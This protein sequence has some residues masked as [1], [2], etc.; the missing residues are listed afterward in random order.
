MG[1]CASVTD[2]DIHNKKIQ[3]LLKA[4]KKSFMDV[5]KLLLLGA[6][7]SG[8]S[9]V[10]KQMI[11]IY[12]QGFSE[13]E[14]KSYRSIIFGNVVQSMQ[15][16]ISQA[17][18]R[19]ELRKQEFTI[20]PSLDEDVNT[21]MMAKPQ[22]GDMDEKLAECIASLWKDAGIQATYRVRSQFQLNDSA[23]YYFE[24]VNA[25]GAKGYI[26]SEPD[27]MRSRARTT[28]VIEQEFLVNN[29]RFR[30]FDVGGQRSERKKWIHCF[31]GVNGVLFV[32]AIST[33]DQVLFE[34]GE[35]NRMV[36]AVHL[37]K[38]VCNSNWFENTSMIL[39]LNKEDLFRQK[40]EETPITVSPV[41]QDYDGDGSYEDTSA[42]IGRIF[43]DQNEK[44][45]KRIYTHLTHATDK[46]NV[47]RVFESVK[48]TVL[49]NG[50]VAAGIVT[51]A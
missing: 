16:L 35:T 38:D 47:L 7:E 42:Y 24:R 33:Y 2:E 36:E 23:S 31:E 15:M 34:D 11:S 12:G 13:A 1:L 22:R 25:L 10:F 20:S 9:T 3:K 45:H 18:Y 44:P 51:T 8:K 49:H 26:P 32:A 5:Q 43:E 48:D 39:F 41:F 27:V 17:K 46:T 28:G 6:G 30:M 37:F 29:H 14:R 50:L 4:E 19:V 40:I 21:V